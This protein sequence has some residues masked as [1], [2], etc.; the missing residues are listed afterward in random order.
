MSCGGTED[1]SW[2]IRVRPLCQPVGNAQRPNVRTRLELGAR[3]AARVEASAPVACSL[4]NALDERS[5]G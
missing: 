2:P 3:R 1:G 4:T 5:L